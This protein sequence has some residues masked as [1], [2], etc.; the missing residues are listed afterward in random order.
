MSSTQ[1]SIAGKVD[2]VKVFNLFAF[3]GGDVQR[4]AEV[5]QCDHRIVEALAHD[6]MWHAKL[7]G[8]NALSNPDGLKREQENNRAA[9]YLVAKQMMAMLES[10]VLD[11]TDKPEEWAARHCVTV[12]EK[13]NKTFSPKP[14]LE[15]AKAA[16]T[17]QDMTYRALGDKVA[18]RSDTTEAS[19]G[20]RTNLAINIYAGLQ[21]LG[22]SVKKVDKAIDIAGAVQAATEATDGVFNPVAD[23]P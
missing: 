17:V 19:S 21:K 2:Q 6:F 10:I 5:A 4:T 13:G 22:E 23:D 11:A 15:I 16:Q 18:A 9:N 12:D 7:K 1:L 3:F 20:E 8:M 14:L